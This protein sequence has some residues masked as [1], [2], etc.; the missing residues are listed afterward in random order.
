MQ[1]IVEDSK[2]LLSDICEEYKEN[3][4]EIMQGVE[5]ERL[6]ALDVLGWVEKLNPNASIELKIAAIFHDIDRVVT[7]KAGGGFK[8]S[9][10]SKKYEEHKK[11]HAKRSAD[12]IIPRLKKIIKNDKLLE[13]V[14]ILIIHHDDTGAEVEGFENMDLNYIVAA[15]SFAFFTSIAPKLYESEG[16]ERIK[17]KIRFMVEKMPE[18]ARAKL[19]EHKLQ[20][21]IF[22]GLK[23]EII[24]EYYGS[25]K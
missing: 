4:K 2:K 13:E 6:H 5:G 21:E 8:G 9:R 3:D 22:D 17:G 7:P 15:D 10:D 24:E 23:N 19:R 20:N 1:N 14:Y 16:E 12:F 11:M 18:F 25:R